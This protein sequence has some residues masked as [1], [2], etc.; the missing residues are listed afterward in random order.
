MQ[1]LGI[2][3]PL[4]GFLLDKAVLDSG[5]MGVLARVLS[6]LQPNRKLPLKSAAT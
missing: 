4:V 6:E 5:A 2:A 3:A 1:K